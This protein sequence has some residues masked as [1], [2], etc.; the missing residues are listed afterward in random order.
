MKHITNIKVVES[1]PEMISFT[2]QKSG[3]IRFSGDEIGSGMW[4]GHPDYKN[5]SPENIDLIGFDDKTGVCILFFGT[6]PGFSELTPDPQWGSCVVY[7]TFEWS[8]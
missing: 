8:E 7:T 6:G 4:P 5:A 2:S 3:L 1:L